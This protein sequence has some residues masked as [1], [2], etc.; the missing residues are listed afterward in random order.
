MGKGWA[1]FRAWPSSPDSAPTPTLGGEL[2]TGLNADFLGHEAMIFRSG[3]PRPA[4]RSDSDQNLLHGELRALRRARLTG[5]C[6]STGSEEGVG[7]GGQPIPTPLPKTQW[8]PWGPCA[9][10]PHWLTPALFLLVRALPTPPC[11]LPDPRFVLAA[12][13][14]DNSDPDDDKV[15]FF[16][17]ETVPSPDGGPGRATVSRVGRVCVVR[18]VGGTVG[19][20][21]WP[22]TSSQ[23]C[24]HL[25]QWAN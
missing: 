1:G 8:G 11:C 9:S 7:T 23:P 14:P 19:L 2:Y 21:S 4:L 12:R 10:P 13:I 16:F 3:G 25:K 22:Y 5:F 17:S 6:P 20:E 24:P 18:A 15:Y